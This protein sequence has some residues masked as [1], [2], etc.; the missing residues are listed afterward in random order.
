MDDVVAK[1]FE[2][3]T[4]LGL[5]ALAQDRLITAGLQCDFGADFVFLSE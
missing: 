5:S 3:A 2:I 1:V 4:S